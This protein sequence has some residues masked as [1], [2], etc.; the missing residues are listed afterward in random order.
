MDEPMLFQVVS[1]WLVATLRVV[2]R[3]TEVMQVL[4]IGISVYS[5][6]F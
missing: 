2:M 5:K 4:S 3:R 1:R 6:Q